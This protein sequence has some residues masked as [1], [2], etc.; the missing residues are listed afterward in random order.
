[1][2]VEG[3]TKLEETGSKNLK[4]GLKEGKEGELQYF[5]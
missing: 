2:K 5:L 3:L 1:L 4:A